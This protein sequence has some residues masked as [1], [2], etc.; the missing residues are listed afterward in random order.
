MK[1]FLKY[2]KDVTALIKAVLLDLDNTLYDE[3]QFVKSGF[4]TVAR[5]LANNFGLKEE[6]I[7][8]RLYKIFI[9]QGRNHV[10]TQTLNYYDI[11]T[12]VT[13]SNI[14]EVY[15]NHTPQISIFKDVNDV[16]P[17]LKKK[18]RLG[19]VTDGLKFVQKNKV[20]ALKIGS[21]FDDIVYATDYGGKYCQKPFSVVLEKLQVKA[22]ESVYVDDDPY[23]G[24]AVAKQLGIR[25]IRMLR[26]E[27]KDILVTDQQVKPDR[28]ISNLYQLENSIYGID[29]L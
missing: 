1:C 8:S 20:K 22:N 28:E 3:H 26:G 29:R 16:L 27:N 15:R 25:T 19:L 12:D 13:F 2:P 17:D 18:Y 10:F 5:E 9:E 23:R 11:Y 7:Y 6:L 21:Y 14:L 24:F 4:K